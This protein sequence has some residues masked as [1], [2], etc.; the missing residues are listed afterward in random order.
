CFFGAESTSQK[1]P[2]ASAE[3]SLVMFNTH[4]SY[5]ACL[6]QRSGWTRDMDI[7]FQWLSAIPFSGGGFNDSAV[8]EGLAEALMVRFTA[9][10]MF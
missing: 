4:G 3:A 5:S 6:V 1:S 2:A 9:H 10:K 8:A 7:F